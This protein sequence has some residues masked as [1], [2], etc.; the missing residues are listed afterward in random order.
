ML[1]TAD[2]IRTLFGRLFVFHKLTRRYLLRNSSVQW[3]LR[4]K[5]WYYCNDSHFF[6]FVDPLFVCFSCLGHLFMIAETGDTNKNNLREIATRFMSIK[7]YWVILIIDLI[8]KTSILIRD[9]LQ[10]SKLQELKNE[11]FHIGRVYLCLNTRTESPWQ[12]KFD[13]SNWIFIIPRFHE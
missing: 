6:Q 11:S 13:H 12:G 1:S 10:I 8:F 9:A 2:C 7:V 5:I 4:G 3:A